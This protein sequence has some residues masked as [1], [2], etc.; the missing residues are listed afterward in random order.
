RLRH[1]KHD[2]VRSGPFHLHVPLSLRPDAKRLL[3]VVT[4]ARPRGGELFRDRVDALDLKADVVDAR[5]SF[6][7]LDAS[8][9]VVLE[10]E[11]GEIDVAVREEN[12]AR[13]GV[14]DLADFLHAERLDVELRG[15]LDVLGG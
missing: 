14:V 8:G 9:H 1:V 2:A 10:V 11:D 12:T 3:N 7:A 15:L 5:E 13:P 4:A 6:P